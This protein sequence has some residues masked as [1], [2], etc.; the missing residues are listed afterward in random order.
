MTR[1]QFD[2]I[3]TIP[4]PTDRELIPHLQLML[5]EALRRQVWIMFLD[6]QSRPL[7]VLIPMDVEAEAREGD[8]AELLQA[9]SCV[10]LDFENATLV[11][12][13]ERPG[14]AEIMDRDRRWL[15]SLRDACV[16]SGQTFRGPFLLLGD[17]VVQVPPDDY[18][19][20]PLV[21]S[22]DDEYDDQGSF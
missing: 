8:A 11:I 2:N 10:L 20:I 7:P 5:E 1:P 6:E 19:G 17:C 16:A 9:L 3:R 4:L 15:G 12:T 21:Y 18:V 14:P 13:L 22:P